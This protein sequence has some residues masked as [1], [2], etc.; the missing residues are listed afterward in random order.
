M[1]WGLGVGNNTQIA[2]GPRVARLIGW[3][4]VFSHLEQEWG[5]EEYPHARKCKFWGVMGT[6]VCFMFH[7]PL[8][9]PEGEP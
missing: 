8:C 3:K 2:E 9:T 7:V 4:T 6:I 5:D 1:R